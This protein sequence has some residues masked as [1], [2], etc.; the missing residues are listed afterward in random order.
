MRGISCARV[1][2]ARSRSPASSCIGSISARPS[3]PLRRASQASGLSASST[4]TAP[5]SA[6]VRRCARSRCWA[7]NAIDVGRP[8][9]RGR[10]VLPRASHGVTGA[11]RRRRSARHALSSE[12]S[13]ASTAGS[14]RR[15]SISRQACAAVVRSRPNARP[16]VAEAHAERNMREIH[17]A[18]PRQRDIRRAPRRACNSPTGTAKAAAVASAAAS[19]SRRAVRG[20]GWPACQSGWASSRVGLKAGMSGIANSFYQGFIT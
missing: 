9:R 16:T 18:L 15:S 12:A 10:T 6:V 13:T 11:A 1:N 14:S 3:R 20:L 8:A 7:R 2:S 19:Q 5:A 17:R 4:V